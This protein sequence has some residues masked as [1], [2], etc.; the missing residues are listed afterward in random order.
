MI[1]TCPCL[2]LIGQRN[3]PGNEHNK[4]LLNEVSWDDLVHYHCTS[5]V[6]SLVITLSFESV[7]IPLVWGVS[8]SAVC[9]WFWK[10]KPPSSSCDIFL[11]YRAVYIN[12]LQFNNYYTTRYP[13]LELKYYYFSIT[14]GSCNVRHIDPVYRYCYTTSIVYWCRWLLATSIENS[15]SYSR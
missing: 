2:C 7:L 14:I 4:L 1:K 12:Q 13:L 9:R 3:R 6:T 15:G 8:N 11:L 10:V 5:Y